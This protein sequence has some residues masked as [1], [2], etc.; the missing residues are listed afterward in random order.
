MGKSD[1]A[2][3]RARTLCS[4]ARSDHQGFL[5]QQQRSGPAFQLCHQ[6]IDVGQTSKLD[7][8]PHASSSDVIAASLLVGGSSS[9]RR[10]CRTVPVGSFASLCSSALGAFVDGTPVSTPRK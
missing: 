7:S 4:C 1:Q 5:G 2:G 8:R 9:T 6:G 3:C 10:S